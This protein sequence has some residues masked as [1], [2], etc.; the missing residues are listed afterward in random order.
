MKAL[1]LSGGSVKG[2]FQ[3][4]AIKAVVENNFQPDYIYGISVGS[5]NTVFLVNNIIK[6]E[7]TLSAS[8]KLLD[9][10]KTKITKPKDIIDIRSNI[11][12]IWN[13]IWGKF[14]GMVGTDP[15]KK[16]INSTVSVDN[17]NKSEIDFSVGATN[18]KTGEI[19]YSHK[20]DA[21]ILD[22]TLAST[23]MPIIMPAVILRNDPFF[24]G[25]LRN[26]VPLKIA[27]DKGA[28]EIIM[29]LCQPDSKKSGSLINLDAN[30]KNIIN[31]VER[32]TD[33]L[34]DEIEDD[35]IDVCNSINKAI[36]LKMDTTHKMIKLTVIRPDKALEIDLQTFTSDD[37]NRLI[38][39][40]YDTAKTVLR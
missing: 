25:G 33:I 5:L 29:I 9:F 7:D 2:A 3:A 34:T 27:I 26:I 38:N 12:I 11:K 15:L 22:F 1:V 21:D 13:I 18:Y 4:G 10:W 35:D 31:L 20:G 6:N 8:N 14:D 32:V 39:L 37:I 24:D 30:Y 28:D 17:L 36:E 16:L 23:A 40:G 19:V